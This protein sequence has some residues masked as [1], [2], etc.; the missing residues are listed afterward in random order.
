MD[1]VASAVTSD[2][3]EYSRLWGLVNTVNHHRYDGYQSKTTRP[4]PLVIVRPS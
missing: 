2:D 1:G 4:I 3:P